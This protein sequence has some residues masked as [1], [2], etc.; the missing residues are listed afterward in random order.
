MLAKE[1]ADF[2]RVADEIYKVLADEAQ[3]DACLRYEERK[4][5]EERMIR[6]KEQALRLLK[7]KDEELQE[8]KEELRKKDA[9]IAELKKA[10]GTTE[11]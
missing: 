3:R 6:E 9:L 7:E 8:I 10:Q 11:K 2:E 4:A 5:E 1:N